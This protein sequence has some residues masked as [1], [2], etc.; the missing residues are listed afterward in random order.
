MKDQKTTKASYET[1]KALRHNQ[2][3]AESLLWRHLQAKQL[4]SVKFRRQ[5]PIGPY[6][7]DFVSF[8]LKLIIEI[9]GG[10]H[11]YQSQELKDT[12][13]TEELK[14]RGY[15]VIRFWNNDVIQNLE[16]VLESIIDNMK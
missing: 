6:I 5:Q 7:A 12:E 1:A 14:R 2:T 11:N 15:R 8:Q 4:Q 10:Q 16:S 3:E 9:D 13:R